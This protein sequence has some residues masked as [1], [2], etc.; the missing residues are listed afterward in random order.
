VRLRLVK[1]MGM[2]VDEALYTMLEQRTD[3]NN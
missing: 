3:A 1:T 2:P